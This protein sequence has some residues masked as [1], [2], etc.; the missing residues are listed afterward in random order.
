MSLIANIRNSLSTHFNFKRDTKENKY[1]LWAQEFINENQH[2]IL[3]DITSTTNTISHVQELIA[4]NNMTIREDNT[5]LKSI[6]LQLNTIR[7][8]MQSSFNLQ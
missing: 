5:K 2:S 8:D 1:L 7:L 4:E 3:P 6:V